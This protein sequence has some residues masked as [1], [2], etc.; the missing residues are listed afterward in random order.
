MLKH[1]YHEWLD[2]PAAVQHGDGQAEPRHHN[3]DAAS[4]QQLPPSVAAGDVEMRAKPDADAVPLA[5]VAASAANET[6]SVDSDA[7]PIA[8]AASAGAATNNA[9]SAIPLVAVPAA[10]ARA[11]LP[12]AMI[13][14][15]SSVPG[16]AFHATVAQAQQQLRRA[17]SQRSARLV[18]DSPAVDAPQPTCDDSG[19]QPRTAS[20]SGPVQAA[21]TAACTKGADVVSQL[22]AK[23]VAAAAQTGLPVSRVPSATDAQA[24][25]T[26]GQAAEASAD[27]VELGSLTIGSLPDTPRSQLKALAAFVEYNGEQAAARTHVLCVGPHTQCLDV[28]GYILAM[29][30]VMLRALSACAQLSPVP[31]L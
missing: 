28:G 26:P 17:S 31:N 11:A 13:Q 19:D 6:V 8:A 12:A 9:A 10:C 1:E 24:Q 14:A 29:P 18:A 2:G 23:A 4:A 7:G 30:C 15:E 27:H 16:H 22:L 3:N 5:S 20:E 21:A 25:Q